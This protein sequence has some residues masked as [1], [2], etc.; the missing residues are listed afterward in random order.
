MYKGEVNVEQESLPSFL[1]TAELLEV[2]GLTGGERQEAE[3][4]LSTVEPVLKVQENYGSK[5]SPLYPESP[6]HIK[7]R[8][9]SSSSSEDTKAIVIKQEFPSNDLSDYDEHSH[10][11]TVDPLA[12][13]LKYE[14]QSSPEDRVFQP[15]TTDDTAEG[16]AP[17]ISSSANMV[18]LG[19]SDNSL[20]DPIQ[21]ISGQ[22]P[23]KDFP[24]PSCPKAFFNRSKLFKHL[25]VHRVQDLPPEGF[26]CKECPKV[27]RTQSNLNSHLR[28]HEGKTTCGECGL[29][30]CSPA[31][32]RIHSKK[33]HGIGA[34][35]P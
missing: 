7:R 11:P 15:S 6:R 24:C 16:M 27:F 18:G 21:G 31:H 33:V 26:R 22:P 14:D 20:Q 25:R 17:D 1:N 2:K 34:S 28:V 4:L 8:K 3:N 9:V 10:M 32:L 13:P 30:C 23:A 19:S 29:V 35:T 12:Q 5:H